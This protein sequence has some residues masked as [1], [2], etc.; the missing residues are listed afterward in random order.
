MTTDQ[1]RLRV[2]DNE[3]GPASTARA[4]RDL[5]TPGS[6][7]LERLLAA[8]AEDAAARR[9]PE[10]EGHPW[11]AME[12]V[13]AARSILVKSSVPMFL[14]MHAQMFYVDLG[15]IPRWARL[16]GSRCPETTASRPRVRAHGPPPP[17]SRP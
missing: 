13:R 2:V 14:Q 5:V 8:I 6:A 1:I 10:R 12:R 16:G 9:E 17:N 15:Q 11:R 4:L 3:Q 7:E